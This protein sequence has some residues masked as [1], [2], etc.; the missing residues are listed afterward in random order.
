MCVFK[1]RVHL[2]EA[3]A[4][5]GSLLWQEVAESGRAADVGRV[6]R[7]ALHETGGTRQ[8]RKVEKSLSLQIKG[9]IEPHAPTLISLPHICN[10]NVS[11]PF[12]LQ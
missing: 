5:E 11:A 9:E 6:G 10:P 2:I 3:K 7:V 12:T 1:A 8:G 4:A